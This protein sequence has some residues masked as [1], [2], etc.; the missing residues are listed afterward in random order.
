MNTA[1]NTEQAEDAAIEMFN[2]EMSNATTSGERTAATRRLADTVGLASAKRM[3]EAWMIQFRQ[4]A[5]EM[6]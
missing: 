2:D 1:T 4:S 5:A 3:R 6:A